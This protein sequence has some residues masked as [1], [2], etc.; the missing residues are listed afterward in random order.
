VFTYEFRCTI[1]NPL[2]QTNRDKIMKTVNELQSGEI[3]VNVNHGFEIQMGEIGKKNTRYINLETG[4]K[5]K[6]FTSKFNFMLQQGVFVRK[7]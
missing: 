3:L 6:S 1:I 7:V 5:V 4:E 2:K